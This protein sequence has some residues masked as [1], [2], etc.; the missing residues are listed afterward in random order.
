MFYVL[1]FS[2]LAVVLVAS[3]FVTRSRRHS[4]NFD[5]PLVEHSPSAPGVGAT[6]NAQA[7][8]GTSDAARKK[9][10][11]ERAQSRHDRR[12]RH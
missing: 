8:H 6:H 5:G 1:V 3:V 7:H 9:R 4:P 12:K 2:L 10:K 11:A